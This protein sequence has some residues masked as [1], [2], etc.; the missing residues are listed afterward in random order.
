MDA[1]KTLHAAEAR[2][3]IAGTTGQLK[4]GHYSLTCDWTCWLWSQ[5][6]S[7]FDRVG[8]FSGG[9]AEGLEGL[10]YMQ[11]LIRHMPPAATTWDWDEEGQSVAQ[12][13]AAMLISWGELFPSFD[14]KDSQVVGKMEAARPP[15]AKTLRPPAD[16]GFGEIPNVGQQGGSAIAL[17]KYSKNKDAAWIFMQWA[18]SPDVMARVSTLGGGASPM[19]I[20]SFEDP[21]V[22]AMAKVSPGTTRHFD[23]IKWTID[24]AMGSAPDLP[25][26][27]EISN[28][29]VPVELGKLLAGQYRSGKECM[30]AIKRQ[31]DEL[32]KP[33]RT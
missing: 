8:M 4:S 21:R 17:S 12:G 3:G 10:A 7:I 19:R 22:K 23:A 18:C 28:N 1:V 5:G 2:N 14:S 25:A 30:V 33:F 13:Q 31:A 6:G 9:D 15:A 24:N 16:A 11:E 32:A 27:A 29:V 26:W 20:S